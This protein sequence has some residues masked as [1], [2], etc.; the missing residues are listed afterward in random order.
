MRLLPLK[1][2][3]EVIHI[4]LLVVF[5]SRMQSVLGCV[6]YYRTLD[7]S[8]PVLLLHIVGNALCAYLLYVCLLIICPGHD[9]QVCPILELA[10]EQVLEPR[11][12]LTGACEPDEQLSA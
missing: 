10:A 1:L 11:S 3:R 7:T 12:C 9:E 5:T 4:M 6:W 2:Q 8:N